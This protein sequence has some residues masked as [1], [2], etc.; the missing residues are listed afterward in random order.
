MPLTA[1]LGVRILVLL[2][3]AAQ[4]LRLVLSRRAL[5]VVF[6]MLDLEHAVHPRRQR[7]LSFLLLLPHLMRRPVQCSFDARDIA[8]SVLHHA[9]S[10]NCSMFTFNLASFYCCYLRAA[11]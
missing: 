4:V 6:L 11:S 5:F 2:V 8:L 10:L 9:F 3:V 7:P 1:R